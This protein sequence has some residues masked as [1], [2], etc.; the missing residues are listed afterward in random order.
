MKDLLL[1]RKRDVLRC[2][3]EKLLSYASGR[4][5][6]TTDRGMVNGIVG[7]AERHG[8]RLRDLIKLVV[9]SDIFADK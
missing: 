9:A 8:A 4:L 7:K 6:E 2:L 5:L 1:E 3:T